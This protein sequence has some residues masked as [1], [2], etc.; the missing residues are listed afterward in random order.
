[1]MIMLI[2]TIMTIIINNIIMFI[3]DMI[4]IQ[5]QETKEQNKT[6]ALILMDQSL[7]HMN[8]FYHIKEIHFLK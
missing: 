6:M 2:M 1:M 4:I 8:Q 5:E 7:I 3:M